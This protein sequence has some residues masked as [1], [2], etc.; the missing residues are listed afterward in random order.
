MR[1]QQTFPPELVSAARARRFAEITL[2][3][4]SCD[5]V[6]ES[7][8]LLLSELVVNAV[9][10][11]R[12]P[13]SVRIACDDGIVRFEVEDA[14][15]TRID[16]PRPVAPDVP[17]GRGLAIVDALADAWGSK[18]TAR[19]KVVWFEISPNGD[20]SARPE[21]GGE[22]SDRGGVDHDAGAG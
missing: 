12:T 16:E 7:A 17:N 21:R 6:V 9:L 22:G 5:E 11:A 8:R 10:H 13:V 3:S 18:E 4:W 19:G 20:S 1:A 2:E 14:D 15:K